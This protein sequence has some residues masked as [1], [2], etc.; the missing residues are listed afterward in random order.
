[1]Y[2]CGSVTIEVATP[3]GLKGITRATLA[4]SKPQPVQGSDP[5]RHAR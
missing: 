4:A 3:P 2:A 5:A 1:M